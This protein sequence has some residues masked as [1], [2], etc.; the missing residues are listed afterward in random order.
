M[1]PLL[2]AHKEDLA[3][4]KSKLKIAER[5]GVVAMIIA[6]QA[7]F[8]SMTTSPLPEEPDE[9]PVYCQ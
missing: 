9:D 1:K 6:N 8:N 3:S 7:V 5:Y 4:L 2:V